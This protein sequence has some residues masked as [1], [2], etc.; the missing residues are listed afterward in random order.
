M[1][2]DMNR[3]NQ[4]II[5]GRIVSD[6]QTILTSNNRKFYIVD[7]AVKRLSSKMDYIPVMFHHKL[8]DMTQNLMGRH[9]YVAGQLR[10]CFRSEAQK[11]HLKHYLFATELRPGAPEGKYS[12]TNY[13]YLDGN[14]CKKPIYR[15]TPTGRAITDFI[16]VV[17][18]A[19][20]KSNYIPC[21]CWGKTALAVAE[22]PIGAHIEV[23]GRIQSRVYLK[24]FSEVSAEKRIAYE[25]SV[26]RLEYDMSN[27]T[28]Q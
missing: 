6:F 12:D 20:Y 15:F 4:A 1:T 16:I 26:I 5:E 23:I 11:R 9:F 18:S 14:I 27:Q 21:I 2:D 22:L 13:I 7:V 10:S 24:Q 19:N 8:V 17:N 3:T 28:Y 25:V